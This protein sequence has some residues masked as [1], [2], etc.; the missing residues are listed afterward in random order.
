MHMRRNISLTNSL[1]NFQ[2]VIPKTETVG[3]L[4]VTVKDQYVGLDFCVL[5]K[6]INEIKSI[7]P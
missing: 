1:T 5:K 4:F 6:Y 2:K 7:I 3:L